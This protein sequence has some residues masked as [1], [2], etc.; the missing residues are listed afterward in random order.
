[1][2]EKSPST[3][4]FSQLADNIKVWGIELG[5]QQIGISDVNLEHI[6]ENFA[7]W[8]RKK[9]HGDMHYMAKHGTKRTRPAELIP[10]TVRVIS[11]R[12]DY[13]PT[14]H[15]MIQQLQDKQK[16]YI[17]RYALGRDYHKVLRSRLIKLAKKN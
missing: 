17:S 12:M 10:G 4:D 3:P 5:F 1:M 7:T 6:E 8:L 16:A 15:N 13:L 11:A 14:N 2:L 9:L